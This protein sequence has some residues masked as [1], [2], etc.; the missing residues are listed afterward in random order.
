[1]S[2]ESDWYAMPMRPSSGSSA[3]LL[4]SVVAAPIFWF[5]AVRPPIVTVSV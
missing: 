4:E 5:V 3:Q 1:L 2:D